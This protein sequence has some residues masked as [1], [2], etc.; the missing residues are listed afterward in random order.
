MN[1]LYPNF[2]FGLIAIIFPIL[3]HLF[4][5]QRYKVVFFSNFQ[6]L[7]NLQMQTKRHSDVKRWLLLIIRIL[8]I[9]LVVFLFA[10]PYSSKNSN[11]KVFARNT[12][13]IFVDNSFSMSAKGDDNLLINQAKKT[14]KQIAM[15]Y[16]PSDK[17]ILLTNDLFSEQFR[18]INRDDFISKLDNIK[19]NGTSRNFSEL[20]LRIS[21]IFI[22]EK[23]SN[24]LVYIISDFQK[25][26][27]DFAKF[28]NDTTLKINLVHLP[29]QRIE[30]IS[31]DSCWFEQP[32][33]RQNQNLSLFV[34]LH[35]Y[36]DHEVSMIPISLKINGKEKANAVTDINANSSNVV[37]LNFV[38]S[39][40]GVLQG[41]VEVNDPG[42]ISFDNNFYLSFKINTSIQ[43]L[44]LYDKLPNAFLKAIFQT[45]SVF[46]YISS[47]INSINYSDLA[48]YDLILLSQP[49]ELASGTISELSKY[50]KQGGILCFMP[51]NYSTISPSINEFLRTCGNLELSAL[52]T[53]DFN[54]QFVN[55][56]H[57]L[58][59]QVFDGSLIGAELP[60]VIRHY[61]V[62][63]NGGNFQN[64]FQLTNSDCVFGVASVEQGQIYVFGIAPDDYFGNFSH[65]PLIVP[66]FLNMAF[67]KKQG[68]SLY[69][70]I[71][72]NEITRLRN[73]VLK[74]DNVL[75]ITSIDKKVEIIPQIIPSKGELHLY[76]QNQVT[77]PGN[78]N[79]KNGSDLISGI[80]YNYCNRESRMDF[81]KSNEIKE[82]LAQNKLS[83]ISTFNYNETIN[84]IDM[85]LNF[86]SLNW[87][88]LIITI[89][90][91]IVLE[92]LIVK[93]MN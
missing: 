42:E 50:I 72:S 24:K 16:A 54:I 73:I 60:S 51:S 33:L 6:F 93:F 3:V 67:T 58:Y 9:I 83:N 40:V 8:I 17:F 48:K 47:N 52:D 87:S 78:Y 76:D 66:T 10:H 61:R 11:Q 23:N 86:F 2:L 28:N 15:S 36:S 84:S 75:K 22:Q 5:F 25:T 35:N 81:F 70:I 91:L 4:N 59:H 88:W 21:D 71:G 12:I 69:S 19:V 62:I 82:L 49:T 20:L 77:I 43:I 57:P 18:A 46:N 14:A 89:L 92:V 53:A 85:N 65:H 30:N 31:I 44:E 41:E 68:E 56:N 90:M 80:S 37:Q 13:C 34:Q 29:H 79:I 1:F 39:E 27:F 74:D 45:D 38:S 63:E 55:V 32:V 26:A 7:Q 64:L